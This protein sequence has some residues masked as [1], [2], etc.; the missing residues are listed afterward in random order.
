MAMWRYTRLMK[1]K[2]MDH[3]EKTTIWLEG[4]PFIPSCVSTSYKVDWLNSA[5][6][7]FL[8]HPSLWRWPNSTTLLVSRWNCNYPF[9]ASI[10]P[11]SLWRTGRKWKHEKSAFCIFSAYFIWFSVCL[12]LFVKQWKGWII[13]FVQYRYFFLLERLKKLP[14]QSFPRSSERFNKR[15]K[16][17]FLQLAMLFS[18]RNIR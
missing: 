12:Y 11:R 7:F 13:L 1:P 8:L 17:N 6:L 16:N 14:S 15:I 10:C 3:H 2:V 18:Q 4:K 5:C 9:P